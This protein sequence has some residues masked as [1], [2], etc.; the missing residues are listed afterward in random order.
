MKKKSNKK[1]FDIN[2]I[3]FNLTKICHRTVNTQEVVNIQ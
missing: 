1:E 2:L 3:M